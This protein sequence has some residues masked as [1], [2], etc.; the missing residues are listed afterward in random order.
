MFEM[1]SPESLGALMTPENAVA[2]LTLALLEIVLGID[3]VIFIAIITARLP[4]SQQARARSLGIGLAV[5]MR[6]LL[7]LSISW[8]MGLTEPIVTIFGHDLSGRDLILLTGGA[9]LIGKSTHEIHNKL[10]ADEHTTGAHA[11]RTAPAFWSIIA[12]ILIIDVVFSLDSVITAIGISDEI[13]IMV[14]AI[15]IAAVVMVIFAG[16]ISRFVERHPT[17]KMLALAF[18]I[19]IGTLLV[20]E[21]WNHELAENYNLKNYAYFAMFFSVMVELLN[22]RVRAASKPV[23]LHNTPHAED[24]EETPEAA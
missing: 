5:L 18:L 6:I 15:V 10:E 7:L 12:Q 13:L 17:M 16:A 19:L 2:L 4:E 9:F 14:I 23:E 8:V 3:N 21:G 11:V 22:M 20:I 1:L 24:I